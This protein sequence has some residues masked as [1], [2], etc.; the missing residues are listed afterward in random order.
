MSAVTLL[1]ANLQTE[2]RC[3]MVPATVPTPIV[4]LDSITLLICIE[5]FEI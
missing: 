2:F 4:L 5:L 1:A 3:M